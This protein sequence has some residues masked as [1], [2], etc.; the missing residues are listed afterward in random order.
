MTVVKISTDMPLPTPRSVISSPIH[1]MTVVPATMVITIVAMV[2]TEPFGISGLAVPDAPHPLNSVPDL[3]SSTY[4]VDWSTARPT[5]RYLV[6]WVILACPAWPSC[7]SVSSRGMTTVSSCRMM[8]AVMYGM[9][10]SANTDSR[11]S[12]WPLSR[13][14]MASTPAVELPVAVAAFEQKATFFSL[15][16]GVGSEA[17]NRNSAMR[18]RVTS[19]FLRR[20]GVWNARTKAVSMRS[21]RFG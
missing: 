3:A 6:Y 11:S 2:K 15:M 12:A 8:L 4:P 16:P 5:V 20:S 21:P 14:T 9:M 13:L 17:P 10:P 19:S 7:F 18:P 1:M